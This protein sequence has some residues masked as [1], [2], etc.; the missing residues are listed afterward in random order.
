MYDVAIIGAGASGM[1]AAISAKQENEKLKV[2]LIEALPRIGKKILA[3]GNG[4]CNLSNLSAD[5]YNYNTT[6]VSGVLKQYPPKKIVDFFSSIGLECIR[7]SESRVYPMSNMATSV[8]DCLRFEIERLG[9]DVLTETKVVSLKNTNGI[10]IINSDIRTKRVILSTGSKASPSQGSDGSGYPLL[11]SLGHS[12]TPLYPGL[13]QLTVKENVKPLKGVKVK[14]SVKLKKNGSDLPCVSNGEVLFTDYGLSGIA[15]MDVSRSVRNH[16]SVCDLNIQPELSISDVIDFIVRAKRH[17]PDLAL[18]DALTGIIP[19]KLGQ[20]IIKKAGLRADVVLNKLSFQQIKCVSEHIKSLEFSVTGTRGY[21][22]A[23]ITVGGAD[24]SEINM[25]TLESEKV[26]GLYCTGE[27]LDVDAPCGG[28]NLQ[29]AWASG[30]TAGKYAA[31]SL[32]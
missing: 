2:V 27:V 1:A 19:K 6:A 15:I 14:A 4:R 26:K 25:T 22:N 7:D 12:I 10:F 9:V 5:E 30:L 23:Q 20:F 29:W 28:F 24:I 13:V 3:T 8:L 18:E 17:N 21:E 16:K 32:L 11:E 31:K